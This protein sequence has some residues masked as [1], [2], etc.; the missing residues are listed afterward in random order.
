MRLVAEPEKKESVEPLEELGEGELGEEEELPIEVEEAEEEQPE[1]KPET[2]TSSK[3]GSKASVKGK[4]SKSSKDLKSKSDLKS[5]SSKTK[6]DSKTSKE[7]SRSRSKSD[8]KAKGDSKSKTSI[9]SEPAIPSKSESKPQVVEEEEAVEPEEAPAPPPP[10]APKRSSEVFQPQEINSLF[11]F[12]LRSFPTLDEF[13]DRTRPDN[14]YSLHT[15][16]KD[17]VDA[18]VRARFDPQPPLYDLTALITNTFP[19]CRLARQAER[20]VRMQ[21]RWFQLKDEIDYVT[22]L[23]E[24]S[25]RKNAERP[26]VSVKSHN[27]SISRFD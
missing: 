10:P 13:R 27:I 7:G 14:S 17:R 25:Q 18:Y 16:L 26:F 5:S 9:K 11:V 23:R 6:V 12:P 21:E 24:R 1:V 20:Q 22:E 8:L 2:T 3:G 15:P 4:R 19:R